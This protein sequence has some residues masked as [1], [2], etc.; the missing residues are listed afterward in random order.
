MSDPVRT[1][2]LDILARLV[3]FDTESSKTNLPLIAFVADYCR[4]HGLEVVT[5]PDASGTKAALFVTAG[6]KQDGGVVL[7]GHTDCVPVTG[8]SWTSDPLRLT[9]RDGRLYGRGTCDMK[10]FDAIALAMIPEFLDAGLRRPIHILLSYDEEVNCLG[11]MD[12]IARFGR[13]LPRPG[14]VIVGE[15]TSMRVA[16][17]HKSVCT[18]RT[19]VHGVEAHSAKPQLG[20]NAIAAACDLVTEL[21][22]IHARFEASGEQDER[23]D[24]PH[25]TVHV[26]MIEGGTARNIL[27]KRCSLLWEYRGL[28]QMDLRTAYN[29]VRDLRRE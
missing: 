28:P 15:P 2:A 9:E 7:S 24:P 21:S 27:A 1:R 19:T 11:P 26:G 22:R 29:L 5:T 10:G 14:A 25:A 12:I 6:P 23:F 4:G 17:A 3:A 20:A 8:Q 13:D 18:Y 16:D